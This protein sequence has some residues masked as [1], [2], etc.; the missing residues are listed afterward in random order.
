MKANKMWLVYALLTTIFWGIWGAFSAL[1][2]KSGFPGTLI[3]IVWSITMILPAIIA[4]KLINW[5]IDHDLKSIFY[6]VLIGFTGA[7]GQIALLTQALKNGPA[8]LIFPIISLSPIIT[9][10]LSFIFLKE[11]V[12]KLGFI[13]IIIALISLPLLSFNAPSK[14]SPENSWLIYALIVFFAWG[15]QAYFMKLANKSMK[16]ESIFFYMTI[17][18]L[19]LIPVALILTDFSVPINW[20]IKGPLSATVIQMLN[21]LG[22]LFIVYAFKYGKAII[23]SPLTNTVSPVITIV[24]S[25]ILYQTIPSLFTI[26]GIGLAITSTLLFS[27][28]ET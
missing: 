4:L 11:R 3:Y 2:E 10:L 9:I 6:G 26:A 12:G 24:L 27:F 23:V 21:S 15:V 19:L 7:G 13:G 18:G 28:E 8:H 25:L 20:S 5:K 1:P 16:A 22:A 14:S 17:T